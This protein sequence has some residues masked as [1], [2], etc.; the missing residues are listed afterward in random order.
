MNVRY[1][2]EVDRLAS[3]GR[4]LVLGT[5]P[6]ALAAAGFYN[7]DDRT[8]LCFVCSFELFCHRRY[9]DPMQEHRAQS[10]YCPFVR[11]IPCGN[12]PL[13][14]IDD[15]RLLYRSGDHEYARYEHRLASFGSLWPSAIRSDTLTPEILAEAGL[16]Y[17]RCGDR[18]I[19]HYCRRTFDQWQLTDDPWARHARHSPQCR[20][21]LMTRGQ[22]FINFALTTQVLKIAITTNRGSLH[23]VSVFQQLGLPRAI[24]D[25]GNQPTDASICYICNTERREVLFMWCRHLVS[26]PACARNLDSCP[27]CREPIGFTFRIFLP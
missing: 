18:T 2:Q 8:A 6:R 21:L 26:C 10:P 22:N 14:D 20:F 15:F 24:R 19:C 5:D 13:P 3:F 11:N 17:T 9:S 4:G 16:Y 7:F 23:R 27:I 12:V 1:G 25:S